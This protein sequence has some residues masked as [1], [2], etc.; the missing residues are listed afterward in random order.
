[1]NHRRLN[2]SGNSHQHQYISI[3][4][5]SHLDW[6]SHISGFFCVYRFLIFTTTNHIF[7]V[8]NI[9]LTYSKLVI[10]IEPWGGAQKIHLD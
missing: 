1:M 4:K 9:G 10:C 8:S 7:F 2:S 6:E 3:T 5:N